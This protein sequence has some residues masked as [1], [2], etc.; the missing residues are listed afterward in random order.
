MI[1]QEI[2]STDWFERADRKCA[3]EDYHGAI[4]D[5]TKAIELK[6][7]YAK[8]FC[9]RGVAKYNLKDFPGAIADYTQAIKLK[10]DY[11]DAY[12]SRGIA[13]LDLVHKN[14]ARADFKRVKELGVSVP[15]KFLDMCK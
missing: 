1:D 3:H 4:V 11:V 6:P 15:K 2:S 12:G 13:H 14:E 8:A 7:G 9:S 5:F 10:P